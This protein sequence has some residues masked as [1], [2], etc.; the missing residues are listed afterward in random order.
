V[1]G[2][3]AQRNYNIESLTVAPTEDPTLSRLTLTTSG[4]ANK[5][6]QIRKQLDKLVEVVRVVD[7]CESPHVERELLLIK[8]SAQ[9]EARE[10]VKRSADI[11]RGQIV[12]VTAQ[13]YTIQLVGPSEKLDAFVRAVEDSSEDVTILEV[14]RT[15][16]SGLG[17]GDQVLSL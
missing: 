5:I 17:R 7:L 8:V 15:G 13:T 14:V 16:V 1:V 6:T 3:F 12:D 10:E 11:F 9:G 4:D 2:L